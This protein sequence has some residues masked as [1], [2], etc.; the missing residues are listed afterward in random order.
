[1]LNVVPE[2]AATVIAT[3]AFTGAR[4]GEIRGM[5]WENYREEEIFIGRSVWQKHITPPEEHEE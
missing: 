3:A 5:Y 4:R 1:M 2:P